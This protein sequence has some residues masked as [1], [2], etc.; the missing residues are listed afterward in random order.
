MAIINKD[1][2]E[3]QSPMEYSVICVNEE[4]YCLWDIGILSNNINFLNTIDSS[5]FENQ[6][7]FQFERMSIKKYRHQSALAIR[8][9]YSHVLETLFA[10]LFAFLQSPYCPQ[11]WIL[12]CQNIDLYKLTKK[13]IKGENIPSVWGL[14][15]QSWVNISN[16]VH[17]VLVFE[18]KANEAL[19]KSNFGELWGKFAIEF[20]KEFFN[21][22]YNSIKH[23]LRLKSGGYYLAFTYRPKEAETSM[24]HVLAQSE[25]GSSFGVKKEIPG[26]KNHFSISKVN[27]SWDPENM[28]WGI[29]LASKSINNIISALKIFLGVSP[30]DVRFA[31]PSDLSIFEKPWSNSN[32]GCISSE[33]VSDVPVDT[34]RIPAFSSDKLKGK[35]EKREFL[36]RF[37]K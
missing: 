1:N 24:T 11:G 28:Y 15:P 31:W 20:V 25:F 32:M 27:T 37:E 14:S 23:G 2:S 18:D 21:K 7:D 30:E 16:Q 33:M 10:F 19:I 36:V 29:K 6:A 8:S 22:E 9:L 35:Y 5:Y 26:K 13:I 17:K 3:L 4:Y 12:N 34:A